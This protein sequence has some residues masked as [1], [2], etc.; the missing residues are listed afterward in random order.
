MWKAPCWQEESSSR[1]TALTTGLTGFHTLVKESCRPRRRLFAIFSSTKSQWLRRGG[2]ALALSCDLSDNICRIGGWLPWEDRT[3]TFNGSE[4]SRPLL[5]PSTNARSN[6]I[7][8]RSH[9]PAS[10]LALTDQVN[11]AS[12][13]ATS[14]PRTNQQSRKPSQRTTRNQAASEASR[15]ML[16]MR[17]A[18]ARPYRK[19][20]RKKKTRALSRSLID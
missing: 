11:C 8:T 16:A 17:Q 20:A 9:V 1:V 12:S 7:P 18:S 6:M 5:R 10:S 13:A 14:V 4:R 19:S 3:A 15:R 2:T